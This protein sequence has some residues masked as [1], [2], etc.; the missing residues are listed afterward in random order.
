MGYL[1]SDSDIR[2]MIATQV[3]YLDG[4]KGMSVGELVDSTIASYGNRTNLSERE[5]GQLETAQY[6]QSQIKENNLQ[7]CNRWIIKDVADD[8]ARSGFYG[9]LIDT[10]D[11]DAIVGM[12]GSESWDAGQG[13][14]DWVEAD[15]GLLNSTGTRQQQ[16]AAE[17]TQKVYEQFGDDYNGF[18]FTGHSLGG[19][20]SE[21]AT[22]TAPDG[23]PIRRCV[24]YDGPGFSDEYITAHSADIRARAQ[25]IDH[26][27][28]SLVGTLLLPLPGTNYQTIAAHNDED[29][30]FLGGY[31]VR[32][33]TRN[34]E[35]GDDGMIRQGDRDILSCLTDPF[36]K[37]LELS[38][39]SL[40]YILCP[41][42]ALF[43]AVVQNGNA[44]LQGMKNEA[45]HIVTSVRETLKNLKQQI[46]NW[47]RNIFGPTLTGEFE[48]NIGYANS[49]ADGMEDV[50]RKLQRVSDEVQ[51]VTNS[52][53]YN[54]AVG[55]LY[56]SKLKIISS[57][58]SRLG[59]KASALGKAVRSCVQYCT[60]SDSRAA[61]L[62]NAL[63]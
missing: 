58:I 35:F 50:G 61:Q 21:H 62:F 5:K 16:R 19:N 7:D 46:T 55:F 22:I 24:S 41:Q 27:Q 48:I 34:I 60:R 42:L 17:F 51:R 57:S 39:F 49:V 40:L 32:H 2:M 44:I 43:Q 20:L 6:I 63:R 30:G 36:S 33:H 29:S 53:R 10:R 28:Y 12:R 54:S 25:Y 52:L 13:L 3:A 1:A 26:Y 14:H 11:G 18:S 15:L 23:M 47:F 31:L 4:D 59:T 9:C 8:N 38:D 45:E 37:G 56:R